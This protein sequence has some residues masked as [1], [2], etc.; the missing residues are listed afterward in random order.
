MTEEEKLKIAIGNG[1][2]ADEWLNHPVFQHVI[3]LRQAE[4][5]KH[6]KASKFDEADVR[7]EIWRK[8]Q[9]FETMRSD[10]AKII[11]DAKLATQK[12]EELNKK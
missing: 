8:A 9:A 12:L 10:L 1:K 7:E 3:S 11:R 4:L 5:F 2:D 6:F